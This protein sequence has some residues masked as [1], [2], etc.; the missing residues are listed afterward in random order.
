VLH[1]VIFI[2]LYVLLDLRHFGA[3]YADVARQAVGNAVTGVVAF[4]L[5]ELL[6]GAVER[7]RLQKTRPR[8]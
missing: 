3:T 4:Q 8:R 2:G 1:A 5:V 7:R 6:P